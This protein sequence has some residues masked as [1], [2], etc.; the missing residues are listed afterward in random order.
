MAWVLALAQPG[1]ASL[2]VTGTWPHQSED[3]L[4]SPPPSCPQWV[5]VGWAVP[6]SVC[7]MDGEGAPTSLP[8]LRSFLPQ[9][10][11]AG[12]GAPETPLP[13]GR[14]VQPRP[15]RVT[16]G[17]HFTACIAHSLVY[18]LS[19]D[20][21]RTLSGAA[22]AHITVPCAE[23]AQRQHMAHPRSRSCPEGDLNLGSDSQ[24]RALSALWHVISA[25]LSPLCSG[26]RRPL[27]V[28]YRDCLR[29]TL[30]VLVRQHV[31]W[32]RAT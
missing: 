24:S 14:R 15:H 16:F 7:G 20:F 30:S 2:L 19:S 1:P 28:V 32:K 21:Q 26:T 25:G 22:R 3:A 9:R 18:I 23:E 29:L 8:V 27:P 31:A 17:A 13:G 4:P 5:S 6:T 11:P 10:E 12:G